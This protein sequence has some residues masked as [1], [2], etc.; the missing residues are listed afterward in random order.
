MADI[1]RS[2]PH[3]EEHAWFGVTLEHVRDAWVRRVALRGF[4]GGA[5]A[6]WET[7]SR[8][9]V[10]DCLAAAPVSELA[11]YRRRTFFT[12]GQQTLFMRCW[13]SQGRNDFAVGHCAPGPN[14]FVHCVAA[15]STGDSGPMESWAT[16]VLYDNVRIDGGGLVLDNRWTSPPQAGWSAANCVLWQCQAATIRCFRPPTANNWALGVWAMFAGDGVFEARSDFVSPISLY[17]AQLRDRRGDEAARR[18][19]PLLLRPE[20]STN[21]TLDQAAG[22]VARSDQPAR[23]LRDVIEAQWEAAQ[24]QARASTDNLAASDLPA[25]GETPAEPAAGTLP[26]VLRKGWLTVD[27]R[28]LTGR[29]VHPKWW[30]GNI[31]PDEA[32]AF[33]PAITRFVPGREGTGFTDVLADVADAMVRSG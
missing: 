10:A 12:Q 16:G 33:G 15:N 19:D 4:A 26:L 21:P 23:R 24:Q 32:P 5:V 2:R 28:V 30:S 14:A 13:S 31:R 29:T 3:S 17:Q 8:I 1:D 27:G 11:G 18:V 25:A 20:S 22:F 7:A 9:T 6:A